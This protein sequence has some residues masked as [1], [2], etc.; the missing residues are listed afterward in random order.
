MEGEEERDDGV[1]ER[2]EGDC[3]REGSPIGGVSAREGMG[4][5][6]EC[7][8][9][10]SLMAQQGQAQRS[11]LTRPYY[12]LSQQPPQLPN[13]NHHNIYHARL[14]NRNRDPIGVYTFYSCAKRAQQRYH[15]LL[16]IFNSISITTNGVLEVVRQCCHWYTDRLRLFFSLNKKYHPS[17]LLH[18]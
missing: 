5:A 1:P 7:E 18:S 6:L 14:K 12:H 2:E 10:E 11:W 4:L 3:E 17:I 13:N 15:W 9:E 8:E 16:S